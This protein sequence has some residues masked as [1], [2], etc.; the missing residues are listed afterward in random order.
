MHYLQ[1][2][3]YN[4]LIYDIIAIYFSSLKFCLLPLIYAET[5][6]LKGELLLT[7]RDILMVLLTAF[8]TLTY[9]FAVIY[10]LRSKTHAIPPFSISLNFSWEIVALFYYFE[11]VDIAWVIVDVFIVALIVKEYIDQKNKKACL[12]LI[13]F[14]CYGIICALLFNRPFSDGSNGYIFLSFAM[15]LIMAIDF[16]IEFKEK[17]KLK[18]IDLMLWFVALFKL[19]GDATALIIY[20]MYPSVLFF[21]IAVLIFNTA[22]IV[23]VSK[24]LFGKKE[25]RSPK[26]IKKKSKKRK[27]R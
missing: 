14:V 7:I 12:Y 16:N 11:Y 17:L 20:R 8:W 4:S 9:V 10:A 21:G 24:V 6:F 22:Y 27:K 15:D 23:R 2:L 18:K 26:K 1:K 5:T 19:L 25:E 3:L 13:S